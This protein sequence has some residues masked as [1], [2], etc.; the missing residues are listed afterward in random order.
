[1]IKLTWQ[2]FEDVVVIKVNAIEYDIL[3]YLSEYR[4]FHLF[5]GSSVQ[6]EDVIDIELGGIVLF[7]YENP[8]IQS[9]PLSEIA[10]RY[11]ILRAKLGSRLNSHPLPNR[12]PLTSS[13]TSCPGSLLV[14]CPGLIET[15]PQEPTTLLAYQGRHLTYQSLIGYRQAIFVTFPAFLSFLG[16]FLFL[17]DVLISSFRTLNTLGGFYTNR[18]YPDGVKVKTC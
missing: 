3:V 16:A 14:A 18:I 10:A 5:E 2:V 12:I 15:S 4:I 8:L 11:E 9:L 6:T 13:L 7:S 1:M 17:E